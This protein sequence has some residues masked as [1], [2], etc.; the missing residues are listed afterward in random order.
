MT[1]NSLCQ[2]SA[3]GGGGSAFRGRP[4]TEE[5]LTLD[6][7]LILTCDPTVF[8]CPPVMDILIRVLE[9]FSLASK[10]HL[11]NHTY[12]STIK[13]YFFLLGIK[14]T[15]LAGVIKFPKINTS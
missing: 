6:P 9:A 13:K 11:V 12:V 8:R 4:H 5:D 3:A 2:R 1:V 10:A 14:F 7:L 15:I